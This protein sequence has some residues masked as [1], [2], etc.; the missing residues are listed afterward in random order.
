MLDAAAFTPLTGAGLACHRIAMQYD[1]GS[2][3]GHA[4][5]SPYGT[6]SCS[7]TASPFLNDCGTDPQ[8]AFLR[9]LFGSVN[10]PNAGALGGR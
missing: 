4:W 7:A 1:S 6:V 5:V 8:N 2:S 9:K 10:G 3:A